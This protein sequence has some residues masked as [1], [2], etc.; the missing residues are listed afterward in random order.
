ENDTFNILT[1]EYIYNGGGV[2]VADFNNDGLPD[3]FFSGNL[4]PNRLYLNKGDLE[5]EDISTIAGIQIPGRWDSG[6]AIADSN[7]DGWMD[8]YVCAT[9][10]EEAAN[11]RN[12]LFIN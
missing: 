10:H 2:G 8:L 6:V 4:V 12:M 1:H 11:R 3:I 7:G 9:M 5:F